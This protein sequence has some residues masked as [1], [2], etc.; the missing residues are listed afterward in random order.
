MKGL[1]Y[2][3][4]FVSKYLLSFF[5]VKDSARPTKYLYSNKTVKNI[6]NKS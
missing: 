1:Y 4:K 3:Q 2:N 5:K 6:K